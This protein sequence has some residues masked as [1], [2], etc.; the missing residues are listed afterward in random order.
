MQSMRSVNPRVSQ[1][2]SVED[3]ARDYSAPRYAFARHLGESVG[4]VGSGDWNEVQ[5]LL[6]TIWCSGANEV[7]WEEARPAIFLAWRS[8]RRLVDPPSA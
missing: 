5:P 3:L 7:L 6:E 2:F 4:A 8:S 1:T